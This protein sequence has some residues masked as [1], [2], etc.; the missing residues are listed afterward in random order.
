M[1]GPT[2]ADSASGCTA[3]AQV[4]L[5]WEAGTDLLVPLSLR[6]SLMSGSLAT[7]W[8]VWVV[9]AHYT[10]VAQAYNLDVSSAAA[11]I[12]SGAAPSQTCETHRSFTGAGACVCVSESSLRVGM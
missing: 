6:L 1:Q 11:G 3:E 7:P 2:P 4:G 12:I 9:N 5:P 8:Q 10:S